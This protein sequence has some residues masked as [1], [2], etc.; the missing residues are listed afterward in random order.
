[1]I[2]YLLICLIIIIIGYIYYRNKN[3]IK[4]QNNI[5]K[6]SKNSRGTIFGRRGCTIGAITLPALY[7]KVRKSKG[8]EI[9]EGNILVAG[10]VLGCIL[11]GTVGGSL[12]YL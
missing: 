9:E 10:P 1:M 3:L 4:N 6:L 5:I 8:K 11:G 7:Y 2:N 12:S